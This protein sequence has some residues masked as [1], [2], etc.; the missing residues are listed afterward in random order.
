[1]VGPKGVTAI[2]DYLGTDAGNALTSMNCLNNPLKDGVEHL[3]NFYE[4]NPRIRT[5]CGLEEGVE[6]IDWSNSGKG[7]ADVALLTADL[8]AGRAAAARRGGDGQGLCARLPGGRRAGRGRRRRGWRG[9]WRP[10]AQVPVK[11][12]RQVAAAPPPDSR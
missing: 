9:W 3:I 1:M 11:A 2:L 8:K 6:D 12:A 5:L 10:W 7:P 4:E